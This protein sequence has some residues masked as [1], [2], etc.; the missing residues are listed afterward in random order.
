M[1]KVVCKLVY[2]LVALSTITFM[3]SCASKKVLEMPVKENQV[4]IVSDNKPYTEVIPTK[5]GSKEMDV[6]LKMDFDEPSN[7][8]TIGLTSKYNLFGF[9]NNSLYKNVIRDKKISLARLPYKVM[10]EADMTYRLSKDIRN[11]IPGCN[12]KHTFN[13]W[14]SSTGLHPHT[15]EYI[16]V[17]DTLTQ[18]FDIVADTTITINL[19]DIMM[20][21]RSVSKK[22]RYDLIYYT[23]LD[24][25]YE[26]V[27]ER[28]PCM[29]KEA[30]SDSIKA[31]L[32]DIQT[33]FTTLAEKYPSVEEL[34]AETLQALEEARM[35]L[36]T[37]YTKVESTN[38]CPKI[39]TMLENYNS[40]VDSIAKLADIKA[41]FAH[42]R[43]K[44]SVPADQL[45]AVARMVDINVAS[46]LV[47]NDVVEKADLVKRNKKLI[48][49]INKKVSRKMTMDKEQKHALSVFKKAEKYFNETCL[50]N[51]RK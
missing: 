24:K 51:K 49:D 33:N 42:K 26:I 39:Q 18:A 30:E 37:K 25:Q 17:T 43:P 3:Q 11:N 5:E 21:E 50:S 10:S 23:N 29:G 1:N 27:I 14:V 22:N 44:L 19:G 7:T 28:N 41:Q 2:S 38:E 32:D 46:Y 6:L 36:A 34:N 8:L 31:M 40:Y 9:K 35:K 16:M 20:M 45:L 15:Q 47:S 48:E 12:D 4:V 13:T